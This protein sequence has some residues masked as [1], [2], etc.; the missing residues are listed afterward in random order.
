MP[1]GTLSALNYYALLGLDN[2]ATGPE[3][4][5]AYR[6]LSK[7]Y[8]P[9]TSP[10][11]Q[12]EAREKFQQLKDAY[13]TLSNDR[14][15]HLYDVKLRLERDGIGGN[16]VA[17]PPHWKR[18]PD[19][20]Y[21]RSPGTSREPSERPLSGGELFVLLILGITLMGCLLLAIA[22]GLT[23]EN[24]P[25]PSSQTPEL[26]SMPVSTIASDGR[27]YLSGQSWMLNP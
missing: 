3:I 14:E 23:R 26:F 24:V 17:L 19:A 8:H 9:D 11:P 6:E 2:G 21:G 10:L 5:R 13:T 4:R 1:P 22:I 7:R 20:A 18:T 12:A 27:I 15:R 16:G 25:L